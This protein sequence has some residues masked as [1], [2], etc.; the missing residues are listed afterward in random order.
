LV[1]FADERD[2]KVR[3]FDFLPRL[4]F[5]T[6]A[7][8]SLLGRGIA[9]A[10]TGASQ[11]TAKQKNQGRIIFHVPKVSEIFWSLRSDLSIKAHGINASDC[12]D[13]DCV[14]RIILGNCH[15]A[16]Q[17]GQCDYRN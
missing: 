5:H 15:A 8:G 12:N 16:H 3:E 14:R 2:R 11:Q 6:R 17:N 10:G 9:I 4:I 1:A 7:I 13:L